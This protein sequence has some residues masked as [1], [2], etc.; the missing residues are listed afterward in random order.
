MSHQTKSLEISPY[1]TEADGST[2]G[3]RHLEWIRRVL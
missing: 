3:S 2:I 1:V